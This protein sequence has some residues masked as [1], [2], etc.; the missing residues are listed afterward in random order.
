MNIFTVA[1]NSLNAQHR[2]A[3]PSL[4]AFPAT[5]SSRMIYQTGVEADRSN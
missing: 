5:H 1:L 2:R 4:H 3:I